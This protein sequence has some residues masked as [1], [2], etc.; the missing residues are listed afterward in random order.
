MR[1]TGAE[2]IGLNEHRAQRGQIVNA[3]AIGEVAQR[4]GAA[5]QGAQLEVHQAQFVREIFVRESQLFADTLQRLIE[6]EARLDADDEQVEG[7]RQ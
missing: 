5:W 2:L 4:I 3:G 6:T 7:I 1:D